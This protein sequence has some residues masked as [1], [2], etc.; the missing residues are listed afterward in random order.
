MTNEQAKITRPHQEL[1]LFNTED[2]MYE[3]FEVGQKIRSM[4]RTLSE[5]ESMQFNALVMDM[6]PYVADE[7]FAKE[8]GVFGRRLVAGAFVFSVGLGLMAHNNIHTF[9][10]GYD[11]LRFI[12]PVFI[13]DTIYTVRTQMEKRPK[14]KEMGLVKVSYEVYKN[15][16]ELALY[17]EH[18]QTVKYRNPEQWQDQIEKKGD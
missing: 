3:E 8:E 14:Y 5:G 16:G 12:K 6:H 4:R 11:R 17:C 18:L 10:Y 2:W 7:I 13:G 15:D 9:S 1:P